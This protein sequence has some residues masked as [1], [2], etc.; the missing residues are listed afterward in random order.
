MIKT[1]KMLQQ[2]QIPERIH[3][4]VHI[5]W[6]ELD[7]L[8][9]KLL[10]AVLNKPVV[11]VTKRNAFT[12]WSL[13]FPEEPLSD[14]DLTYLCESFHLDCESTIIEPIAELSQSYSERFMNALFPY[15]ILLSIADDDGV[16]FIGSVSHNYFSN[17]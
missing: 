6:Y 16:W 1:Q 9:S 15:E 12:C 7:S 8:I 4:A 14:T 2:R 17:I 11:A 5:E 13:I 10:S 3:P